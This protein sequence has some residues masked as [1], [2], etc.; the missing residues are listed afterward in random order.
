MKQAQK[1]GIEGKKE[2]HVWIVQTMEGE[3]IILSSQ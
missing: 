1:K 2:R 3:G